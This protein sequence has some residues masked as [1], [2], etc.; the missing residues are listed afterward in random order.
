MTIDLTRVRNPK[1]I[2]HW[3]ICDALGQ[4]SRVTPKVV[5]SVSVWKRF[6]VDA[7]LHSKYLPKLEI[8]RLH[9]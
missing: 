5:H 6:S 2:A 3:Y 1:R 9:Q 8:T 4:I 7:T